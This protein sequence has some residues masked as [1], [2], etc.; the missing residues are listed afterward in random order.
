MNTY[1]GERA[2]IR[3]RADGAH[4]TLPHRDGAA[5]ATRM[6]LS[7]AAGGRPS[8]RDPQAVA[9]LGA[10]FK[11]AEFTEK[12]LEKILGA[13]PGDAIM[14]TDIPLVLRRLPER[15]TLP[16][17]IRLFLIGVPVAPEIVARDLAPVSPDLLASLGLVVEGPSGVAPRV[18]FQPFADLVLASDLHEPDYTVLPADYVLGMNPT[19]ASVAAM[20][21]RRPVEAMLDVGTGFGVQALYAARHC[22]RVV[23]TDINAR[24]L[25]FAAFNAALN[26]I[27]NVEFREGSLFE[28]V[29]GETFDLIVSNPPYVVSPESG[30]MFRDG[31]APGD[32]LSRALVRQAPA[33]LR[34]GG[35][36]S[37]RCSWTLKEGEDGTDPLKVWVEESGCDAL[38]LHAFTESPF[39]YAAT[40]NRPLLMRHPEDIGERIDRW[41]EYFRRLG[42]A[43]LATGGLILRRRGGGAPWIHAEHLPLQ[44]DQESGRHFLRMIEAQDWFASSPD[45]ARTVF[46]PAADLLVEQAATFREG[47]FGVRQIGLSFV[48]GLKLRV[49]VDLGTM[50]V[51]L[52]CNG[53]RPLGEILERLEP[54][55]EPGADATRSKL[56]V[57]F[58]R[59]HALGF[60]SRIPPNPAV[61]DPA[62][63]I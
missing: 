52:S 61:R 34:E 23:A 19:S 33:H 48:Q 31:R 35:F 25:E 1:I 13:G 51:L 63:P 60:V 45:L 28:P 21:I 57:N 22:E 46:A 20:T 11:A 17:L 49:Y 50:N 3:V 6:T 32:S 56:A 37:I 43:N 40:W 39:E 15:G 9:K 55:S 62:A 38:L 30:P 8:L 18:R 14:R 58:A 5:A 12:S 54:S 16:T 29:A 24:A 27:R 36:A 41:L 53:A 2:G 10:L 47:V 7:P 26:G 4:A 59:L 42:V 44:G